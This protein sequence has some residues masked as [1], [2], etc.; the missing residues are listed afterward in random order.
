ME[1][2]AGGQDTNV[3]E[4]DLHSLLSVSALTIQA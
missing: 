1:A 3:N 4:V 2:V